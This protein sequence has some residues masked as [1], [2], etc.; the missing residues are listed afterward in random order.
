MEN[1]KFACTAQGNICGAMHGARE[2]S[3]WGFLS[4]VRD[5]DDDDDSFFLPSMTNGCSVLKAQRIFIGFPP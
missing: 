5:L 3:A 2:R 4:P 1:P